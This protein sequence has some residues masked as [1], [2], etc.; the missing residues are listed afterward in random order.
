MARAQRIK[1]GDIR[2]EG[3]TEAVRALRQIGPDAAKE[4][5]AAS[6]EVAT[7]VANDARARAYSLGSTAA[8]VAPTIRPAAGVSSAGVGFGGAANPEAGGAEFGSVRFKQFKPWRGS[9]PEAGYF[10]YPTIRADADKVVETYEKR[11]DAIIKKRF[12]Q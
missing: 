4:S 12:P 2:V 1:S 8:H 9:G 7:F 5:R 10:V 6:L 11:W 3:L